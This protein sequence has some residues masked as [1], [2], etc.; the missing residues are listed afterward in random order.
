MSVFLFTIFSFFLCRL[1][2]MIEV[3]ECCRNH[4][5]RFVDCCALTFCVLLTAWQLSRRR[6]D[7]C[8]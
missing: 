6:L 2:L 5:G 3:S 7:I 4:T 8:T 1:V